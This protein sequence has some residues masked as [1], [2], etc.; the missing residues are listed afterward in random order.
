MLLPLWHAAHLWAWYLSS[1]LACECSE[2][3][4]AESYYLPGIGLG[5][6]LFHLYVFLCFYFFV[7]RSTLSIVFRLQCDRLH[8]ER[9]LNES[10][11]ML[12]LFYFCFYLLL[13]NYFDFWW[14]G[15]NVRAPCYV[16]H[17]QVLQ[18]YK[19]F[20][21]EFIGYCVKNA[22]TSTFICFVLNNG[23]SRFA[24]RDRS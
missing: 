14:L 15:F 12:V 6:H 16:L 1:S 18:K 9:S 3:T 13:C 20:S 11:L 23:S 19:Y 21:A 24:W 22:L 17:Y 5:S 2:C 4:Y 7:E 8:N 10:N